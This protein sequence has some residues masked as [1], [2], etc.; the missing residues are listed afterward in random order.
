MPNNNK[1]P[2]Q[3][4]LEMLGELSKDLMFS[5]FAEGDDCLVSCTRHSLPIKI[6]K[7]RG[8]S[9][10]KYLHLLNFSHTKK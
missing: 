3:T 9:L 6:K 10:S 1:V 5:L 2:L 4:G 7:H 8:E